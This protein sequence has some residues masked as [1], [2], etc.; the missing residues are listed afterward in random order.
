[1]YLFVICMYRYKQIRLDNLNGFLLLFLISNTIL[2]IDPIEYLLLW[3]GINGL[4][5]VCL[6]DDI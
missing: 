6:D 2:K 5:K 3:I 1:M 4:T